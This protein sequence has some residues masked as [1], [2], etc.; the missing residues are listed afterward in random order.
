MTKV[1]QSLIRAAKEAAAMAR[2]EL[3]PAAPCPSCGAQ[4]SIYNGAEWAGAVEGAVPVVGLEPG[5]F[6]VGCVGPGHAT[7]SGPWATREQAINCWN[8]AV[9]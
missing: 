8:E 7:D 6:I 2:G 4:P 9:R 1:G 3:K 5:F